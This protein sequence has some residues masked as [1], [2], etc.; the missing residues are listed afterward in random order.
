MWPGPIGSSKSAWSH[1]L[2]H[3]SGGTQYS[4]FL[5]SILVSKGQ[6]LFRTLSAWLTVSDMAVCLYLSESHT[7]SGL[8]SYQF[9]SLSKPHFS[10]R[11]QWITCPCHMVMIY[12][13]SG[14]E[15][16]TRLRLNSVTTHFNF[17]TLSP[18]SELVLPFYWPVSTIA[19]N[20]NSRRSTARRVLSCSTGAVKLLELGLL[21]IYSWYNR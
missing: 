3:G 7:G 17:F 8:W 10:L 19:S 14:I 1:A 4:L 16:C 5:L 21:R 12:N 20:S 11:F 9:T 15:Q 18:T 6:T 2:N 13:D